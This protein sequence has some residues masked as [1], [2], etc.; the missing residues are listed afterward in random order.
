MKKT[1]LEKFRAA[2]AQREQE[3]NK[4][5]QEMKARHAQGK[6]DMK[7]AIDRLEKNFKK[8]DVSMVGGSPTNNAG[9]GDIAG[10]GVGSQ[11]EPGVK[12]RNKKKV[13]PFAIFTRKIPGTK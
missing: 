8:E 10:I 2:S 1:A 6:E 13:V 5:E 3:H 12:L 11:G 4:R 7:A 9:G